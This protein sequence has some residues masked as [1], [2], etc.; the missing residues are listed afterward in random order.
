MEQNDKGRYRRSHGSGHIFSGLI[1][2]AAGG[3]LLASRMGAPIP[4]WLFSWHSLLI[5]IGLFIGFR[6]NFKNPG[7]II[8]LSIGGFFLID[9]IMPGSNLHNYILPAILITVGAFFIMRPRGEWKRDQHW[10]RRWNRW[11]RNSEHSAAVPNVITP[12]GFEGT[13]EEGE[14]IDVN[15]VFGGVKKLILSKN[16]KGG[17][18][19][20]FM[21]GTEI[22]LLQADI[23]RPIQLEV[24]AVFGGAKIVVPSN[25][26]VKN[27]V[28]AVF[29]GVE[30]KR[31][32]NS[33]MPDTNKSITLVG[34]VVFGGIEIKNF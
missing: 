30:D 18:M 32:I 12:A 3:L 19:N 17:E 8:M 25:W 28:T 6:S 26:D 10:N 11:D 1:L 9:D 13:P 24:N 29:G 23:Q 34:T 2:L 14:Y 22:N 21:G 4:D 33:A 7:W 5:A 20:C 27:E 31:S 16:F 15:A